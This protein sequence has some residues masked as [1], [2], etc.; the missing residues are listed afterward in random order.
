MSLS[1][2]ALIFKRRQIQQRPSEEFGAQSALQTTHF[3]WRAIRSGSKAS[4]AISRISLAI[5]GGS[6]IGLMGGATGGF[7]LILG[8]DLI[9]PYSSVQ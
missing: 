2:Q 4:L 8:T 7:F 6:I 1:R 9:L 5:T 3:A